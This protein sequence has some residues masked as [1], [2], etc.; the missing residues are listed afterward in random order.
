M[1]ATLTNIFDLFD[2]I[3]EF[4]ASIVTN[5]TRQFGPEEAQMFDSIIGA[6]ASQ[7]P[8]MTADSFTLS[9]QDLAFAADAVDQLKA[10]DPNNID[11][12]PFLTSMW[13]ALPGPGTP[14]P[15][16]VEGQDEDEEGCQRVVINL[17]LFETVTCLTYPHCMWSQLSVDQWGQL[18]WG[19]CRWNTFYC[20]CRR[21]PFPMW[22]ILLIIGAAAFAAAGP[23]GTLGA[24]NA[25]YNLLRARA[26]AAIIL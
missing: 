12:I 16:P 26:A 1:T 2:A 10:M 13:N 17:W 8:N 4:G 20:Y 24:M 7:L 11:I 9:E 15:A 18:W 3:D 21:E 5:N 22:I 14:D 6:V 25:L 23:A 19:V